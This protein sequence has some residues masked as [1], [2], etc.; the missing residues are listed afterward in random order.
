VL[1]RQDNLNNPLGVLVS[2]L[3]SGEEPPYVPSSADLQS[4]RFQLSRFR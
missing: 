1:C 4:T 2:R 3:R